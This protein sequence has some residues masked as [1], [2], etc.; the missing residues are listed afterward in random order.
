MKTEY[1]LSDSELAEYGARGWAGTFPLVDSSAAD[2]LDAV[3]RR[4]APRFLLPDVMKGNAAPDTFAKQHWYKS[5]HVHV[6]EIREITLH[7]AIIGRVRSILGPNIIAWGVTVTEIHPTK[8][9]RWHVDVE[10]RRWKGV[11]IFLGLKNA[12]SSTGLQLIE[13]SHR[14]GKMPQTLGIRDDA[15]A[16]RHCREYEADARIVTP[17]VE[18]GEFFIFEGGLWHGSENKTAVPRTAMI[19]QYA[20]PDQRIEIPLNWDDPIMWHP[21]QPPVILASGEDSHGVNRVVSDF[22][23]EEHAAAAATTPL[24]G[25]ISRHL[26]LKIVE[27]P[28]VA[29]SDFMVEVE[30]ENNSKESLASHLPYP[31]CLSYHWFSAAG[32]AVVFEGYRTPLPGTIG[33]RQKERCHARIEVPAESGNYRLRVTLIQEGVMWFDQIDKPLMAEADVEVR[34]AG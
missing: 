3:S 4:V 8:G 30:L 22:A 18:S 5:M 26:A 10:H 6:P 32:K 11:S 1:T 31:V 20:T 25:K 27:C 15:E 14:V 7:P 9:H 34:R 33:P 2:E 16:L 23:A 28:R 17:G 21:W 12:C 29:M 13:G 19:L 24:P